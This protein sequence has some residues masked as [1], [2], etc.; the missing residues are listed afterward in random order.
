MTN[1]QPARLI[2]AV[3]V[4][5]PSAANPLDANPSDLD[6]GVL[7]SAALP[8]KAAISEAPYAIEG[9]AIVTV[10]RGAR[11]K[12]E[13][14]G[15]FKSSDETLKV[16]QQQSQLLYHYQ[17]PAFEGDKR[18]QIEAPVLV[19]HFENELHELSSRAE[20]IFLRGLG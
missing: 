4:A 8:N 18:Y 10:G 6:A 9:E 15:T 2:P 16:L 5:E 3:L 14:T 20:P 13:L 1:F 12:A 7:T 17:G 19:T 11:G